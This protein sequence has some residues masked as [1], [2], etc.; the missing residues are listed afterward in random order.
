MKGPSGSEAC[1]P[2]DTG[3][4]FSTKARADLARSG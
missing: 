3:A 2:L 1:R 4:R